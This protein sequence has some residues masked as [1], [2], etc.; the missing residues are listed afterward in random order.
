MKLD[1]ENAQRLFNEFGRSDSAASFGWADLEEYL[2]L[3]DDFDGDYEAAREWFL[4]EQQA[5]DEN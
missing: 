1:I 3:L 4:E 5:R 2:E